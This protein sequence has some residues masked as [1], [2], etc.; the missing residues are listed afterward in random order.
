MERS[1]NIEQNILSFQSKDPP[2]PDTAVKKVSDAV[3]WDP[4]QTQMG[5]AKM[6]EEEKDPE[7]VCLTLNLPVIPGSGFV[8]FGH[9]KRHCVWKRLL[10]WCFY[11]L[12][13]TAALET[14]AKDWLMASS[15][16]LLACGLISSDGMFRATRTQVLQK[17][18]LCCLVFLRLLGLTLQMRLLLA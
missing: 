10:S 1:K 5:G 14:L 8:D 18:K 12:M 6:E 13:T 4:T 2:S 11:L 17:M 3:G 7:A 9:E 15:E 16:W